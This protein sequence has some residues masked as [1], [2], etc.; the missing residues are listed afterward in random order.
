[1]LLSISGTSNQYNTN[2]LQSQSASQQMTIQRQQSKIQDQQS[3]IQN[4]NQKLQQT[5]NAQKN[6]TR[7][8]SLGKLN[9]LDTYV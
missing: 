9:S 2:R 1:M 4:Q 6:S 3:E 5:S 7:N 8:A